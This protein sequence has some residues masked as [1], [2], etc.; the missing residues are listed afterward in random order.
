MNASEHTSLLIIGCG[1]GGYAAAFRAA[2]LG[3]E[4]TV[5]DPEKNPG[6]VCLYRGCIPTKAL[7]HSAKIIADARLCREFGIEFDNLHID[8]KKINA[9]KDDIVTRMTEGLGQLRRLRKIR[10]IQGR[11]RFI[12]SD[13]V[14]IDKADGS[15]QELSYD[16]A[17]LATGSYPVHLPFE[18]SSERIMDSENALNVAQ[19]PKTLLIVGGG[20]I[21]LEFATLY[22]EFGSRVT[23]VEM[24]PDL[25][26]PADRDMVRLLE[27]QLTPRLEAVH[28][29]TKVTQIKETP[30]GLS[31]T[32]EHSD[33]KT[34][35]AAFEKVLVAVGRKP[36]TR[37]LGL[38]NTK[39]ELDPKGF[40]KINPS[41]LTHDPRVYAIGDITGQPM[42]AHKASHE[43]RVAAEA[44]AGKSAVFEPKAIPS[45]VYTN[46]EIV[47]CGLTEDEAKKQNRDVNVLK[48]A[49]PA[50]GRAMTLKRTDGLTKLITDPQD[51][52]VLG[53]SMV[54]DSASEMIT[55][56]TLAIEMGAVA[57]DIALTVHPHPT[58]SETIME[59]A[60]SFL[61]Q[62]T[63]AYRVKR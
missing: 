19:I 43:G 46:P 61:G 10:Y 7:L 22:G 37:D 27:K 5:V 36:L 17:I 20:Y 35:A 49:W 52:R 25:L 31:V 1:P 18:P 34:S 53:L 3:L 40:V 30:G 59:A 38:E 44:I 2:D 28:T 15:R 41:R 26:P 24:T 42:L 16:H 56:G 21:G 50:S 62:S 55:E 32:L 51:G 57:K 29:S 4:V 58:L 54:G 39:M 13:A 12:R 33:G 6:G 45:V 47:W 63:H 9:C 23:V 8:L 14:R 11:A 60:E 48:F